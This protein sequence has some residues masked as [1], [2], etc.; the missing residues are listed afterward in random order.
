M[1][2]CGIGGGREARIRAATEACKMEAWRDTPFVVLNLAS[3]GRNIARL[4]T[5]LPDADIHYAVKC[6]PNTELLKTVAESGCSFEVA[7]AGEARI[8]AELGVDLSPV[9]FSAPV[10]LPCDI[11]QAFR[12]GL[13]HF[14]FDSPGEL[15]KLAALAPGCSVYLRV[16]VDDSSSEFPLSTKFGAEL[17][18]ASRLFNRACEL[19]LNPY[20]LAFHVGSQCGDPAAWARA[21]ENC[22]ASI[23]ELSK[24]GLVI[25][26]LDIGGGF[27]APYADCTTEIEEICSVVRGALTTVVRE[28]RRVVVEPGRFIAAEAGSLVASVIGLVE[29]GGRRI[30]YLDAG[31]YSGLLDGMLGNSGIVYE[32][33]RLA[34]VFGRATGTGTPADPLGTCPTVLAGPTCDSADML[35]MPLELP[36]DLAIGDRIAILSAG[37]YSISMASGFCGFDPPSVVVVD[38]MAEDASPDGVFS[39][40]SKCAS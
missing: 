12:L 23:S 6:N 18:S 28:G 29:R 30:A 32:S 2:S 5:E 13:R 15:D 1:T 24:V 4:Q 20:G 39:G 7:S 11:D 36:A 31:I 16:R 26:M 3:V 8:L 34:D 33:V 21:I 40:V 35:P 19:G 14:A 10:K 17:S 9:L 22:E 38:L 37:A 27:P 25:G